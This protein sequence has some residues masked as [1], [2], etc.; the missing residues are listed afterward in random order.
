MDIETAKYITNYYTNLFTDI[1]KLA[2]KHLHHTI[3]LSDRD[4][5]DKIKATNVY[6]KAGWLTDSPDALELI[7]D[8]EDAFIIIT[9][10]RLITEHPDKIFLN[11]CPECKRLA[12]TPYAKQCRCGNN[13]H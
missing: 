10:K 12:R 7:K 4:E 1:E 8:G 3:K 6:K 13:W 2:L 9:A 11:Y 5:N